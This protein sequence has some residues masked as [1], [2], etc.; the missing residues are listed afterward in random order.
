MKLNTLILMGCS[1][2]LVGCSSAHE[3][4]Y[5]ADGKVTPPLVIP[6]GVNMKLGVNEYP[7]PPLPEGASPQPVSLVPPTMSTPQN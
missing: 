5:L 2:L 6:A 7:I 1:A 3:R 4:D